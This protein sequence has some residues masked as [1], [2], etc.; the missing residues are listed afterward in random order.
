M[1]SGSGS[2]LFGLFES[3]EQCGKAEEALRSTDFLGR[4]F[5]SRFVSYSEYQRGDRHR[6]NLKN[7]FAGESSSGKTQVFGTCIRRFESSLPS[8]FF[9]IERDRLSKPGR[10]LGRIPGGRPM[11]RLKS[12][13]RFPIKEEENSMR[14]EL[15]VF[16]RLIQSS[17]GG[18]NLQLPEAAGR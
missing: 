10:G 9:C 8:H 15:V 1:L 16:F 14:G 5:R 12:H 4:I 2:S 13:A 11:S 7:I 17:V 6:M 3:G 18:R